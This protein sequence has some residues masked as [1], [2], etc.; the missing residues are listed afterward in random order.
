MKDTKEKKIICVYKLY[1]INDPNKVYVGSSVDFKIRLNT[2]YKELLENK[3]SNIE[4]QK[5]FKVFGVLNLRWEIIKEFKN[6]TNQKLL[7]QESNYISILKAYENGYNR[8]YVTTSKNC[9]YTPK[10]SSRKN[11]NT[12]LEEFK[13][14]RIIHVEKINTKEYLSDLSF[15]QNNYS[16]SWWNK[17]SVDFV[18]HRISRLNAYIINNY[19]CVR[20]NIII[21]FRCKQQIE[22]I[23]NLPSTRDNS[24]KVSKNIIN[25][26]FRDELKDKIKHIGILSSFQPLN[27]ENNTNQ[28]KEI[29]QLYEFLIRLKYLNIDTEIYIHTPVCLYDLYVKYLKT[30]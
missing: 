3:H 7:E 10:Y 2:H 18:T 4:L 9:F 13:K 15:K 5:D 8:T 27:L 25:R 17:Q 21:L 29:Y 1:F 11:I 16:D 12:L 24:T 22:N 23:L 14:D 20:R 19:K 30:D 6:I 28:E 26:M